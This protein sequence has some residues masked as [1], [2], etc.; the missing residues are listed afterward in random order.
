MASDPSLSLRWLPDEGGWRRFEITS[1]GDRVAV[2]LRTPAAAGPGT[3]AVVLSGDA[4]AVE[5]LDGVATLTLD[6]PLLGERASPK[7]TERLA[8]CLAD[9]PST[10]ADEALLDDFAGQAAHDVGAALDAC[11]GLLGATPRA[12]LLGIGPGACVARR[13]AE[14]EPRIGAFVLA[15]AGLARALDPSARLATGDRPCTTVAR[16]ADG[17]TRVR[18]AVA[19]LA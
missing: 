19:A 11:A 10:P 2:R 16:V 9:G 15:P 1:R 6:L 5:P 13:L 18:E 7:W 8:R 4:A 3:L 14:R 12:A 17:R